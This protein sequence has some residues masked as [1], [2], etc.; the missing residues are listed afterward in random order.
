MH[1]NKCIAIRG[2]QAVPYWTPTAAQGSVGQQPTANKPTLRRH[3][4]Y[5]IVLVRICRP[6]NQRREGLQSSA[7]H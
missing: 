5:L 2:G 1:E 3:Q 7:S 4:Y 6:G